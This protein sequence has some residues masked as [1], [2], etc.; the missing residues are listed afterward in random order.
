MLHPDVRVQITVRVAS[1]EQAEE[2]VRASLEE[3]AAILDGDRNM[4]AVTESEGVAEV[5]EER[6]AATSDQPQLTRSQKRRR[7]RK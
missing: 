2:G 3:S 6:E 5:K 1:P 4:V 7:R